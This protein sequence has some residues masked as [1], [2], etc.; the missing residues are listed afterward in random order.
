[1]IQW[2]QIVAVLLP[3]TTYVWKSVNCL[4]SQII[5]VYVD[6]V[7]LWFWCKNHPS[8]GCALASD[9]INSTEPMGDVRNG[10]NHGVTASFVDF[11]SHR[12]ISRNCWF[13]ET[14]ILF[15]VI[16]RKKHWSITPLYCLNY[17]QGSGITFYVIYIHSRTIHLCINGEDLKRMNPTIP[18]TQNHKNR[19]CVCQCAGV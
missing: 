14:R 11:T 5:N 13:P 9:Y 15:F 12:L 18:N 10:F 16:L 1:M 2:V 7:V 17:K 4:Q 6:A 8:Y 3:L 19:W